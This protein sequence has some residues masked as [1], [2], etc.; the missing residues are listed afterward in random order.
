M[1]KAIDIAQDRSVPNRIGEFYPATGLM[2]EGRELGWMS[3]SSIIA[4]IIRDLATYRTD[5]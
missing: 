1:T 4:I 2:A 5:I 3:G